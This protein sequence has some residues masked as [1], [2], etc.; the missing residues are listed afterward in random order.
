MQTELLLTFPTTSPKGLKAITVVP[1]TAEDT[2]GRFRVWLYREADVVG[3][4]GERCKGAELV[5]DRK[6]EGRFPEMKELVSMVLQLMRALRRADSRL[7]LSPACRN[8]AFAI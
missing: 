6:I 7:R 3:E 8:S 2:G 4:R 1:R 5:W